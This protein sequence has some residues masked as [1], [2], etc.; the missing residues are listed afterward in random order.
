MRAFLLFLFFALPAAAQTGPLRMIVPFPPGGASDVTARLVAPGLSAALARPIV[1]ENRP[2]AG[3]LLGAEAIARAAPDGN[4]I[5]ISNTSPHGIAP[6]AAASPPYDPDRDFTHIVLIA[7][8]PAIIMVRAA[9]PFRSL[10]DFLGAAR[11]APQG[12]TFGSTGV[13]SLQH[14]QG[15]SLA[16]VSGAR[17]VHVP[18]RGTGPALT[19]LLSGQVDSLFTP[20]AGATGALTGGQARALVVS[21]AEPFAALPGVP[22]F[23]AEG[24]PQLTTTSWT[25]LS[26]PR[27][28]D[29]AFV[30]RVNAAVN[31]L[32]ATPDLAQRLEVAGLYPPARPLDAAGFQQVVAD[33]LRDWGPVVRAAGLAAN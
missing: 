11:A 33:F 30:A 15:V 12:L 13:G 23:A 6:L 32:V 24:F 26:G 21:T 22:T 4:T 1:I 19:D 3:G 25:G 7:E 9:S 17:L 5:G 31:A 10:A 28:L 14:L 18:Y 8:T 20:L 27:G 29:P 2:G 16:S